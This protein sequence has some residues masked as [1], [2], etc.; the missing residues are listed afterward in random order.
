M[1]LNKLSSD[2]LM[3]GG[4]MAAALVCLGGAFVRYGPGHAWSVIVLLLAA[5]IF[6]LGA[7][8]QWRHRD[9]S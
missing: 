7:V 1:S 9:H 5:M 8:W 6:F 4:F 3:L 2:Y